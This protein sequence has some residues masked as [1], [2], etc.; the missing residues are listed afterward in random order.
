MQHTS[1]VVASC[2]CLSRSST[3]HQGITREKSDS[4]E[5]E[6]GKKYTKIVTSIGHDY[7]IREIRQKRSNTYGFVEQCIGL[8]F[9]YTVL[10]E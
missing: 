2:I 8:F 9:Q 6:N 5:R 7:L 3:Y 10:N 1:S 4:G